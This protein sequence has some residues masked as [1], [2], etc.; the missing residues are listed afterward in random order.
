MPPT[1]DDPV[2]G[3]G[4][5]CRDTSPINTVCIDDWRCTEGGMVA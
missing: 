3:A 5:D 1:L 4:A 2:S